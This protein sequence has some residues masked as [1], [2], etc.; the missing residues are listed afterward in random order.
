MTDLEIAIQN[1][2]GH[3]ICLCKNGKY[4]TDDGRGISPVMKFIAE[5]KEL[6]R[7]SAADI[8]VGKAAAILFVRCGIISVHGKVMS[9][10][11]KA[12]LEEHDIPCSYDILTK[13]IINRQ[14]TD[15]CPMEKAVSDIYDVETGYIALKT[16][17]D[18]LKSKHT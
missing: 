13:Q 9:E 10:G 4:F 5:G 1:L 17:L 2:N 3:S 15:I 7:Y 12:Y 18:E 8:I 14:G 6:V 11:G 16:R